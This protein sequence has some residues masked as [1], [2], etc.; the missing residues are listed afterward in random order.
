MI[1]DGIGFLRISNLT[2]R[3]TERIL[4][5]LSFFDR[6]EY[7][8]LII[9]L[10]SNPGG[11]LDS[12]VEVADLFFS[13]GTIVGTSGRVSEEN[14]RFTA[15]PGI[16]IPLDL[17]VV[18]LIDG[19][20][21]SASEILAGALQDRGRATLLGETSYGKGS[22]QQIRRVGDGG[23]RLTMSK[24]YLPSGRF[25]DEVG[26]SPDREILAPE[27]S[28]DQ[29]QTYTELLSSPLVEDWASENLNPTQDALDA[30]VVE[31][32][33]GDFD[34]PDR[35]VRRAVRNE[36]NRQNN[37]VA[38]YDLDFDTVLQEA[39]RMLQRGEVSAR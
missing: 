17:P 36:V 32:Q 27:L 19:G 30:F 31:L 13:S 12:V 24:Y 33:E 6:N 9:D 22:V 10:R 34:L 14:E 38:P 25:I 11:L 37:T 15:R 5:A 16:S 1:Q 35:W 26:V 2:P 20:S 21:A 3:T 28:D 7:R 18:V 29:Q 39:V 4:E 8:S 23:F